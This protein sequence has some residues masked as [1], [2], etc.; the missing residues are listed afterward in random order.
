MKTIS[1]I[2]MLLAGGVGLFGQVVAPKPAEVHVIEDR[3]KKETFQFLSGMALGPTVTGAPYSAEAVTEN[4]QTLYDGNRIV[5]KSTS[6][7]YRDSQ[8]RER[9]EEDSSM[10]A[11]FISD[12]VAK[13]SYTLHPD[14][15]LAEKQ[16]LNGGFKVET[17][18]IRLSAG[19]RV[20]DFDKFVHVGTAGGARG[21]PQVFYLNSNEGEAEL[22]HEELG[23][24]MVEGVQAQ[25]TRYSPDHSRGAD[26]QRPADRDH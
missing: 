19:A 15:M 21:G 16:P 18:T 10:Q 4:T 3:Q 25:G 9:R 23:T 2:T 6:K 13:V 5:N 24:R 14:T 22:K 20:V 12:P 11:I 26:W 7:L 1:G 17:G 8:G